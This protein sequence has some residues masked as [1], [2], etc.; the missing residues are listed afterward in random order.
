MM[1]YADLHAVKK[2]LSHYIEESYYCTVYHISLYRESTVACTR[3][4]KER[5]GF[6]SV[7]EKEKRDDDEESV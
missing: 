1:P 2:C 6:L 5:Q 4:D 3:G 7:G